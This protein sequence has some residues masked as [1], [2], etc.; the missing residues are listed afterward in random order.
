MSY[1]TFCQSLH[2]HMNFQN[3]NSTN[4]TTLADSN[5]SHAKY[6]RPRGRSGLELRG[7]QVRFFSHYLSSLFLFTLR[8]AMVAKLTLSITLSYLFVVTFI[9]DKCLF[10]IYCITISSC[11]VLSQYSII[12]HVSIFHKKHEIRFHSTHPLYD[13]IV[14]LPISKHRRTSNG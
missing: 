4:P 11:Y 14:A 3:G 6:K 8:I 9:L 2:F 1:C 12:E 5:L 13:I 10:M 7:Y